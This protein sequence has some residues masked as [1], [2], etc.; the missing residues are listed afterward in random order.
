MYSN[1]PVVV[2]ITAYFEENP[3]LPMVNISCKLTRTQV[4]ELGGFFM[5]SNLQP[6]AEKERVSIKIKPNGGSKIINILTK[7][8][9]GSL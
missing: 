1:T 6:T 8:N 5:R 9:N 7:D 3:L 2:Y 4:M